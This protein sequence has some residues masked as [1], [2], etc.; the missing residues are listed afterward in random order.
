MATRP[1]ILFCTLQS[2]VLS[3]ISGDEGK[4]LQLKSA[5]EVKARDVKKSCTVY[6]DGKRRCIRDGGRWYDCPDGDSDAAFLKS[7]CAAHKAKAGTVVPECAAYVPADKAAA[8]PAAGKKAD[9]KKTDEKKEGEQKAAEEETDE[10]ED[11][12]TTQ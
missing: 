3:C 5:D 11:S 12:T 6:I 10:E 4:K 7:I 8:A 9:E 2:K 1:C